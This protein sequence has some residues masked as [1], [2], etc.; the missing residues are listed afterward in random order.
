MRKP[1]IQVFLEY[2]KLKDQECELQETVE[3]WLMQALAV[4]EDLVFADVFK[5]NN[6]SNKR[7]EKE[8]EIKS[9]L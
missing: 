5:N 4:F 8:S 3:S 1:N 9:N 2:E 7:K 6:Y